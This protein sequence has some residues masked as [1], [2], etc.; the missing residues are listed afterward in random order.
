M[1]DAI[2]YTAV[3]K[4]SVNAEIVASVCS[5]FAEWL[6]KSGYTIRWDEARMGGPE[7][8]DEL[9]YE[10]MANEYALA[11]LEEQTGD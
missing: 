11:K 10:D 6:E 8:G 7:S 1:S 4:Q 9:S 3:T 5:D 2:R